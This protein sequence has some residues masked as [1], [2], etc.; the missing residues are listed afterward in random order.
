MSFGGGAGASA[1]YGGGGFGGGGGG[2]FGGGGGGFGGGGGGGSGGQ[3]GGGG[4]FVSASAA[5]GTKIAGINF[6]NGQVVIALATPPTIAGGSIAHALVGST[7]DQP[8]AGVT[9]GDGN[10]G[11]PIDT[12]TIT[13]SDASAKL[14]VGASHPAGVTFTGGNGSYTL[15]GSA[16]NITSELDALTLTAPSAVTGAVEALTFSLSDTSSGY[17]LATTAS[18]TAFSTT[19]TYTGAIQTFTVQTSGYYDITAEGA[20]GGNGSGGFFGVG[21]GGTWRVRR[22][23]KR[24]RLSAGRRTA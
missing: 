17:P 10:L 19:Y 1:G 24:R 6:G 16:A 22:D 9:I 4:S 7:T 23:G 5:G 14:A 3:G 2:G 20:R 21:P 8:F 13:L 11:N 12:L 18:V 15:T